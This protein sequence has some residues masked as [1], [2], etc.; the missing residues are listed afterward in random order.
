MAYV[1]EFGIV[2]LIVLSLF[3]S[4]TYFFQFFWRKMRVKKVFLEEFRKTTK[5][6]FVSE[7]YFAPSHRIVSKREYNTLTNKQKIN[8]S[9][10]YNIVTFRTNDVEWEL[11]FNIIK[12]GFAFTELM[13]VRAFPINGLI[14]S[15]G[16]VE[17]N[18]GRINV[19]TNNH[20]LTNILEVG[21]N[22]DV[23][24]LMRY[25]GDML[26]ISNNN[27]HFKA[28]IDINKVS[29]NRI[30]DMIKAINGI[31]KGIYKKDVIEY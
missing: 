1:F 23:V 25:D 3:I 13:N 21:V 30:M 29:L 20:Y 22:D 27:L 5:G 8:F 7:A 12:E 26:F 4:K 17:R 2:I 24:W 10:C 11:F 6:R 31:K 14:K 15:E 19:L 18:Y 28:F 9:K 16:N